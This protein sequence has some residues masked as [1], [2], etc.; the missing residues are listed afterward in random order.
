MGKLAQRARDE[1]W[2]DESNRKSR[3]RP[4][5]AASIGPSGDN[6]V[7]WT[8]ATDFERAEW[9]LPAE[10][11]SLYYRRKIAALARAE[12]DVLAIETLGSERE[13]RVALDALHEVA[14]ELP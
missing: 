1:F 3:L 12:P 4:I 7:T 9:N 13:A 14:P 6:L 8:G 11:M 5:V 10:R 2:A